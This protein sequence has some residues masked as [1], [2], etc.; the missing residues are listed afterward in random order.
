MNL[1]TC[2]YKKFNVDFKSIVNFFRKPEKEEVQKKKNKH[3]TDSSNSQ[4]E[5]DEE[6]KR[7]MVFSW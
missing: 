1:K 5:Q 6:T 2:K 3:V 7:F 4:M